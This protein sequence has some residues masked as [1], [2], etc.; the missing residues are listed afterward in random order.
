MK[1]SDMYGLDY[2]KRLKELEAFAN[3]VIELAPKEHKT[4]FSPDEYTL[5]YLGQLAEKLLD[6]A[7]NDGTSPTNI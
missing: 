4:D 7:D 6:K 5:Y 3:K 2:L 1:S